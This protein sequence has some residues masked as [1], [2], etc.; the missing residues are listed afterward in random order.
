MELR[1]KLILGFV[2]VCF[3]SC[4]SVLGALQGAGSDEPQQ[5]KPPKIHITV[6]PK[7]PPTQSQP[8]P[9]QETPSQPSKGPPSQPAQSAGETTPRQQPTH[10]SNPQTHSQQLPPQLP[11]SAIPTNAPQEQQREVHEG[12]G[13]DLATQVLINKFGPE[14]VQQILKSVQDRGGIGAPNASSYFDGAHV[15]NGN[16]EIVPREQTHLFQGSPAAPS[17]SVPVGAYNYA[18]TTV[19]GPTGSSSI[20]KDYVSIPGGVVLEGQAEI[21]PL[22]NLTYDSRF[23]AFVVDDRAVFFLKVSPS[24]VV[25]L[26]HALA[27][28]DQI[29][30]SLGAVLISYG[31]LP[32]KSQLA[33]NLML[34]D[35]FLGSIAFGWKDWTAGYIFANGYEPQQFNGSMHAAVFFRFSGFQFQVE[36]QEFKVAQE[37]FNDQF[38]PLSDQAAADGGSL[39][40]EAAIMA[41]NVPREWELNLRHIA[42]NM[43][44]YRREKLIEQ[45]FSYGATAAFLRGLK[46]QGVDL[47][48]LANAMA[49][50]LDSDSGNR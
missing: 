14:R 40:D 11:A 9:S 31:A 28:K 26:C 48:E 24:I 13:S 45:T 12:S 2:I 23:N 30:V 1:H 49:A 27:Q 35:H 18:P 34:T 32:K 16:G 42:E 7:N 6:R 17:Q 41:G 29:G 44:Y 39:P 4:C 15:L 19:Q 10:R 20:S 37:G 8:T 43:S 25:E 47:E 3:I 36:Q 33:R 50:E 46:A 38:I 22:E 5:T 21:G